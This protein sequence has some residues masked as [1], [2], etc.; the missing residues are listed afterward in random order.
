MRPLGLLRAQR[1]IKKPGKSSINNATYFL[2]LLTCCQILLFMLKL[3]VT[4]F[5][6]FCLFSLKPESP[7]IPSHPK[8]REIVLCCGKIKM[9]ENVFKNFYAA[10]YN[11]AYTKLKFTKTCGNQKYYHVNSGSLHRL[12]KTIFFSSV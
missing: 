3:S 8:Q 4:S 11:T 10:I 2:H 5:L 9:K 6:L 12:M 7:L 1:V